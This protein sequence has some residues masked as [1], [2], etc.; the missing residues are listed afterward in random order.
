MTTTSLNSEISDSFM[1]QALGHKFSI[2]E[3]HAVILFIAPSI[4]WKRLIQLQ[5]AASSLFHLQ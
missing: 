2:N 1:I 4:I 5:I 3:I